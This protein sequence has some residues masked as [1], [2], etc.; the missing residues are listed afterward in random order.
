MRISTHAAITLRRH[1]CQLGFQVAGLVEE[2]FRFVTLHPLFKDLDV[3]RLFHVAHWYL[4][5]PPIVLG[6]FPVNFFW[7][8][9]SFG[10]TKNDHRPQ[11]SLLGTR[12]PRL[13]LDAVNVFNDRV[14]R[15]R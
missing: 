5:A 12:P 4:M 15:R 14:E 8:G 2:V 9:P 11:W 7:T 6:P 13:G 10:R 1:L 3:F